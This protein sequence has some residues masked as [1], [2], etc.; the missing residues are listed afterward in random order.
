VGNRLSMVLPAGTVNYTY[1]AADQLLTAGGTTFTY[2]GNGN[3]VSKTAGG[4][5]ITYAW[6][7][8]NRM[9]SV[10][11]GGANTQ[12]QYDGDGNRVAQTN[13]TG[14]Y[15]YA[16]DVARS[17]PRVLNENGPDGNIS[18]VHGSS[19][20]S[21]SSAT[22][23]SYYQLDGLG[24]VVDVTDSSGSVKAAYSY[25]PWGSTAATVDLLGNEN[26][27]RFAGEAVDPG[28]NLLYLR[29]RYYDT[30]LGRF[31]SRDP[32]A[33]SINV[34]GS[35]T[36]YGYAYD[37]PLQTT[38]PNGKCP[39]CISAA[40]GAVIGGTVNGVDYALNHQGADFS[41][42][43]F[44]ADVAGGAVS[45]GIA[46]ALALTPMG[47]YEILGGGLIGAGSSGVGQVVTNM[48]NGD[49]LGQNV[50]QQVLIG[51]VLGALAPV[52]GVSRVL[53]PFENDFTTS[54][55]N[56]LRIAG[57]DVIGDV[58]GVLATPRVAK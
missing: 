48:I 42:R 7:A 38:D 46:G 50:G 45:G 2:D 6:D 23:Q 5:T 28:V 56:L 36:R 19:V 30:A 53:S 25:D 4:T 29:A 54:A 31:P 14:T 44:G 13:S 15:I 18:Y 1:D 20:I 52:K 34:P 8:M 21:A 33:E 40:I 55:A 49:P 11:G 24:S 51:G 12:Y 22:F 3:Q 16:N 17:L 39:W 58:A 10:T 35:Y 37:N 9:T 27:Y 47:P 32:Q 43:G 57:N 26:K 41:W